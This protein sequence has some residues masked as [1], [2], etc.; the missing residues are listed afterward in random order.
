[1]DP[2]YE[3]VQKGDT[4]SRDETKHTSSLST[5]SSTSTGETKANTKAK[6]GLSEDKEEKMGHVLDETLAVDL[7]SKALVASES[8]HEIEE[9]SWDLNHEIED[10]E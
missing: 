3:A 6:K 5:N 7:S 10:S 2:T 4:E 1:M 9:R 8:P